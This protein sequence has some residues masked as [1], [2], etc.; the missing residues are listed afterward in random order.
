MAHNEKG[1][2]MHVEMIRISEVSIP[3]LARAHRESSV[4]D[5]AAS[6][7]DVGLMNPIVVA[8]NDDEWSEEKYLLVAGAGRLAAVKLLGKTEIAAQIVKGSENKR[9]RIEISENIF[10]TGL[11][12]LEEA[13]QLVEYIERKAQVAQLASPASAKSK[14]G[15]IRKV[16]RDLNMARDRVARAAKIASIPDDVVEQIK[17][18]G[19]D[20]NQR[21]LLKIAKCEPD[22]RLALIE[23]MARRR[24]RRKKKFARSTNTKKLSRKSPGDFVP[25]VTSAPKTLEELWNRSSSL[26]AAWAEASSKKRLKFGRDVLLLPLKA[27]SGRR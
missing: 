21:A 12:V 17:I 23:T 4:K 9:R 1:G 19:L 24:V 5:L 13:K 16:A 6:I 8:E 11:T 15:G 10:R 18:A 14:E 26:K 20:D 2:E 3:D 25:G 22:R 7:A 27:K